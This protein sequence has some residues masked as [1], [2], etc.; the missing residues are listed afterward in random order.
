MQIYFIVYKSGSRIY[1]MNFIKH[2]ARL[3]FPFRIF[4]C[5]K[6]SV[7]KLKNSIVV[8]VKWLFEEDLAILKENGNVVIHEVHDWWKICSRETY[9]VNV[10]D[11]SITT[12]RTVCEDFNRRYPDFA[13]RHIY[14]PADLE[15]RQAQQ[16]QF[17]VGFIGEPRY[18][19]AFKK[20]LRDC[21]NIGIVKWEY[22]T[23][24]HLYNCQLNLRPSYKTKGYYSP[25]SKVATAAVC[26]TNLIT[27][28]ETNVQ[29]LLPKD[30]PYLVEEEWGAVKQKI[31][32]AKADFQENNSRWK[33]GLEV[34][35]FLLGTKLSI[36]TIAQ[37]Y[38]D[39]FQSV[40]AV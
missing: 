28:P 7:K 24:S 15:H 10:L 21:F 9:P 30:Y 25:N 17:K 12:T 3:G 39:F 19:L 27:F 18:N 38:L 26:R 11:A 40:T 23:Y 5:K 2:A 8:L 4:D 31:E 29:D 36:K 20:Q 34:M 13:I 16:E 14:H 37:Q 22:T 32:Q 6:H 35:D 1:A 33:Y